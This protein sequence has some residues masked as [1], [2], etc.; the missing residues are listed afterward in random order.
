MSSFIPSSEIDFFLYVFL[1]LPPCNHLKSNSWNDFPVLGPLLAPHHHMK[2]YFFI[3]LFRPFA[4]HCAS[5]WNLTLYWVSFLLASHHAIIW[6]LTLYLN[7]AS[8]CLPSFHHLKSKTL[9][10]FP[11][12]SH[13]AIIWNLTLEL[14]FPVFCLLLAPYHHMKS[15]FLF[16]FS[17]P[18]YST[19]RPSE[20]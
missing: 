6:N 16:K 14:N 8:L 4:F 7:I 9:F 17:Q 18:L 12:A 1:F 13:H 3:S 15:N 5:I 10:K 20:I 11:F 19:I 2:S